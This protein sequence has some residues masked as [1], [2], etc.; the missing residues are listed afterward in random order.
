M[1]IKFKRKEEY[2]CNTKIQALVEEVQYDTIKKTLEIVEKMN[3]KNEFGYL[4]EAQKEE[5][6]I[7][8]QINTL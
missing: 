3:S 4:T 5:I 1:E 2:S 6:L 7:Q 8:F